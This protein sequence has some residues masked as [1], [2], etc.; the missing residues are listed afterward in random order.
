[1]AGNILTFRSKYGGQISVLDV[2]GLYL[3]LTG[4]GELQVR[5][6][7]NISRLEARDDDVII[8]SYPKSGLHWIFEV[9]RMLVRASPVPTSEIMEYSS[10]EFSSTKRLG[11]THNLPRV[12][13]THLTYHELPKAFRDRRCKIVYITR[14]PR[15]IATSYFHHLS[16]M[17]DV[18]GQ[19]VFRGEWRDFLQFFMEGK[20]PF[21]SWLKHTE[22]WDRVLTDC[23]SHPIHVVNFNTVKQNP[24][25]DILK[26]NVF[27]GS[28]VP[29]AMCS[30]IDDSTRIDKL[31]EAKVSKAENALGKFFKDNQYP[32]Y[33]KGTTDDWKNWFT[34]AQNEAMRKGYMDK[35]IT[36][37]LSLQ[38]ML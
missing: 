13:V 6:L 26:L 3:P 25:R 17:R 37:K 14:D 1:M 9:V 31:R 8:C 10:L 15:A 29:M 4:Y 20:V 27:L 18:A 22:S 5:H 35:L 16:L 23:P 11:S 32:L 21:N 30:E 33:R 19:P 2:D 12:F 38:S 7:D 24:L 34:V 36:T 28:G